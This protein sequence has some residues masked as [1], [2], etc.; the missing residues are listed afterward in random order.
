MVFNDKEKC[1]DNHS[2]G[3][4]HVGMDPS[5]TDDNLGNVTCS[6]VRTEFLCSGPFSGSIKK[7]C[8]A[9]ELEPVDPFI[10]SPFGV[11]FRSLRTWK[12]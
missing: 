5:P 2:N 6:L 1:T 12:L 11:K 9:D 4:I 10:S 3:R 8:L 7:L